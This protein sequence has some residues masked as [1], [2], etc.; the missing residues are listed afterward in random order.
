MSTVPTSPLGMVMS[1]RHAPGVLPGVRVAVAWLPG[2]P[3]VT[4]PTVMDKPSAISCA[5]SLAASD[6]RAS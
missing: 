5:V 4:V 1:I 6:A 2:A 3:V